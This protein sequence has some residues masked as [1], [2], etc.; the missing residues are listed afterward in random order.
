MSRKNGFDDRKKNNGSGRDYSKF[1]NPP[2][3]YRNNPDFKNGERSNSLR[4]VDSSSSTRLVEPIRNKLPGNN[5]VDIEPKIRQKKAQRKT[6]SRADIIVLTICLVL[7]T[8]SV[9][10][11]LFKALTKEDIAVMVVPNG[12]VDIP[13]IIDGIIIREETM[14]SSAAEGEV[15]YNVTNLEKVK[16][17]S[18][19]CSIE[20]LSDTS[21]LVAQSQE[22]SKKIIEMQN[23]RTDVSAVSSDVTLI[24][25][26]M[27]AEID[28][29]LLKMASTNISPL[30]SLKEALNLNIKLRNEKLLNENNGSV[31]QFVDE[32]RQFTGKIDE[33]RAP[34][35]AAEGGIVSYSPDGFED[36]LT[37]ENMQDLT[38][39]QTTMKVNADSFSTKREVRPEDNVFKIIESNNWYIAAFIENDLVHD[40]GTGNNVK[41]YIDKN[42]EYVEHI[43]KIELLRK[44]E[45]ESYVIFKSDKQLLDFLDMRTVS[46]KTFDSV[47]S[48]IKIPESAICERTFLK[49]PVSFVYEIRDNKVVN[50]QVGE[51]IEQIKINTKT[52][53]TAQYE[54]EYVYIM[55]DFDNIRRGDTIVMEGDR[56]Q[57]YVIDEIITSSGVFRTNTGLATFVS[58]NTEGMIN[59]SKG[60]VIL[61]P[62]A[63]NN[64]VA[65]YDRIV[66]DVANRFVKEGAI[67]N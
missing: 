65:L 49:I 44:G 8:L 53:R 48:G 41:L 12:S 58:I 5:V 25:N 9:G 23:M 24:N 54:E 13:R 20:N 38:K 34:I 64:G 17:G 66:T 21:A 46:F 62:T 55:Q 35:Y 6:T 33:S 47:Y 40:W 2:S 29:S 60:Y 36:V 26:K 61:N 18:M 11:S 56:E 63:N 50:K 14:Y 52:I 51:T 57:T 4:P 16:K 15:V 37:I 7:F 32:Y 30:Y 43:F 1:E 42:G 67:I 3:F 28:S 39:E 27:K 10:G 45:T 22:L 31:K 19:V 59:G